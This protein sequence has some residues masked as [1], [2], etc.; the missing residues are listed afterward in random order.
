MFDGVQDQFHH[1]LATSRV[2]NSTNSLPLPLSFSLYGSSSPTFPAFDVSFTPHPQLSIPATHL[3]QPLL[4]K[5]E[6]E[7]EESGLLSTSLVLERGRLMPEAIDPWSNEEVLALLKIRSSMENWFPYFTWELVSRK[8]GDLG[9]KRSAENCKE[10]FEEESRYLNNINCTKNYR[11]FGELEELYRGDHHQQQQQQNPQSFSH[12]KITNQASGVQHEEEDNVGQR[13]ED[14]SRADKNVEEQ[15]HSVDGHEKMMEKTAE[16]LRKRKR[17]SKKLELF[18]GFCESIVNRM[19]AHQEELHSKIIEDMVKRDEEKIAREEAWKKQEME[20][21]RKEMEFRAHEQAIAGDRQAKIIEFL[22]KFTSNTSFEDQSQSLGE[23]TETSLSKKTINNSTLASTQNPSTIQNLPTS[24]SID[25]K[26][27]APQNPNSTSTQDNQSAPTLFPLRESLKNPSLSKVN[28]ER[29]DIGKRWPRD[30]VQALINIK[31]SLHRNGDDREGNSKGPLWERISKEML[32]LGFKRSAKRCKEKWE[33]INKYFRKTKD[34]KKRSVGSRTCPYFH[35][36]SYL[37]SQGT[38]MGSSDRPENC[39]SSP[40]NR[41]PETS[42][43][44]VV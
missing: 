4:Q 9:F 32:N 27:Q 16:S 2:D 25:D 37:Y 43:G 23:K 30:E 18:K 22:K 33:N 38:I 14:E 15:G 7:K 39:P 13:V 41:L 34:N 6:E 3:M 28:G 5:D 31:C 12:E 44:S 10:K 24:S 21:I 40:E 36:L 8:M 42:Y 1:F 20:R 26:N 35:Q 29:V 11:L 17:N 19:M